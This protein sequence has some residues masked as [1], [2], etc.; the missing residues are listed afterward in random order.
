MTYCVGIE[1]DEG[2]VF[3]ADTRTNASLDDVRVHRKL[4][5]FEYPGQAVFA[6][7]S[8]GNLATTQLA[9]SK[10]QRDADD[11][12]APR[13][14]RS[15]KHLF[16][17]AE[18][19]GEVLVSSQVK[20]SEQSQHSGVSVQSTLILG[21][22][23]AG[24][25]PGLYMIYPLGN[26]IATSPETPYLQIGES[27][28][29]KP[30]LDRIIRPE[31]QLEDAARTALVSLDSTIR[32]NLSVGM[33]IDVALIRRNDLR[34]TERLRLEADTPLYSEIHDTWSRKLEHAVRTLP[35]FPWEAAMTSESET[36]NRGNL[37]PLP[38]RRV[39]A[40]RDPEDQSSQ[41]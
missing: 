10:L 29:G 2:L 23:I 14:L 28:Y 30:I 35:R 31:M 20:L 34:V 40:R 18:Y 39:P 19:V 4:H 7:M 21:G 1:V 37:P 36:D 16:E 26:A 25:R 32:S 41:Q 12:D 11:P 22:Q 15:F 17:V 33:P 13:N 27:K 8:A 3:A 9:I 6:L 5:V 24:E 38:P